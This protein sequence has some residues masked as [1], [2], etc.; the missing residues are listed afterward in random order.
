MEDKVYG[1]Q[2]IE[3]RQIPGASITPRAPRTPI[4][5]N[6]ASM[7]GPKILPMKP[8]PLR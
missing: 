1:V 7:I 4:V 3:G 5:I 6:H 8:V 2:R